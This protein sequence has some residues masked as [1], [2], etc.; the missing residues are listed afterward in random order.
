M[1]PKTQ[2]WESWVRNVRR[3]VAQD[4]LDGGVRWV[5]SIEFLQKADEL[6]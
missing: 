6:A 4:Q 5:G 1:S 3:V 2:R